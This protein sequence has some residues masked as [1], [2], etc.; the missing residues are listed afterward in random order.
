MTS[1]NPDLDE[2][3]RKAIANTVGIG[4]VKYADLSKN[5]TSDYIFN[6]DTMLSFEGNTAPYLQYAYAR[7][8]SI[9]RKAG[10]I[11]NNAE[12]SL[13]EPA[14]RLLATKLLQFSE[15]VEVVAKDGTPN[16]LCNYLFELSGYFMSFYEACP[17]IKADEDTKQSRLKLAHLTATTLKTGLDLLGIDVMEKM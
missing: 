14:E 13:K 12:I 2:A 3:S 8:Q 7:I 1:K 10:E 11:N 5:R 9:F 17:I 15:A 4:A 6:W 16:F